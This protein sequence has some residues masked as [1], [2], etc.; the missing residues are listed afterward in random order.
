[1]QLC[2]GSN[3][4]RQFIVQTDEVPNKLLWKSEALYLRESVF[5][6]FDHKFP[7]LIIK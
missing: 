7:N 5:Q 2:F 1:M 4:S 6:G 3:F